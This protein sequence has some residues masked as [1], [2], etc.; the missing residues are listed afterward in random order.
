MAEKA[1]TPFRR[2]ARLPGAR[3]ALE[4]TFNRLFT[5]WRTFSDR[6][7]DPISPEMIGLH[8]GANKPV[9][10]L[11]R[12]LHPVPRAPLLGHTADSHEIS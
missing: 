10:R 3:D 8:S 12:L 11:R 2:H 5:Q 4:L 9:L 7:T 1:E 6:F